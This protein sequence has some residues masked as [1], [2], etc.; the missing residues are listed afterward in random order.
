[1]C[2]SRLLN[3]NNLISCSEDHHSIRM[4][5]G[6]LEGSEGSRARAW[7]DERG[8]RETWRGVERHIGMHKYFC[9]RVVVGKSEFVILIWDMA[10]NL[11]AMEKF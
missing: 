9:K 7:R 4:L 2:K 8:V 3:A 11:N 10:W 1:M 6:Y 5:L